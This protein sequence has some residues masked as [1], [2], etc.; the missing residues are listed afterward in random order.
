[1]E[2]EDSRKLSQCGVNWSVKCVIER[3][4]MYE[5]FLLHVFATF[6]A[7]WENPAKVLSKLSVTGQSS[8]ALSVFLLA[9][10]VHSLMNFLFPQSAELVSQPMILTRACN[11][12]NGIFQIY[13]AYFLS[14]HSYPAAP[15]WAV[16]NE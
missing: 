5:Q 16:L 9:W 7:R 11:V 6:V 14:F 4:N 12:L 1:M 2:G 13:T 3:L 15:R 10:R 8:S